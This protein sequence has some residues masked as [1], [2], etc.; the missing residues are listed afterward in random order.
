MARH[1]FL[2]LKNDSGKCSY[3]NGWRGSD[4]KNEN[5]EQETPKNYSRQR[6]RFDKSLRTLFSSMEQRRQRHTLSDIPQVNRIHIDFLKQFDESFALRF[7]RLYGLIVI[8]YSNLNKSVNFAVSDENRFNDSFVQEMHSFIDST[9]EEVTKYKDLTTIQDFKFLD[10]E[11]VSPEMSCRNQ[12]EDQLFIMRL[13]NPSLTK[14]MFEIQ[15]AL[16]AFL[17][18]HGGCEKIDEQIYQLSH[19]T[20]QDLETLLSNF[21]NILSLRTQSCRRLQI[22]PSDFGEMYYSTGLLIHTEPSL[23]VIGVID[24]GAIKETPCQEILTGEGVDVSNSVPADPF[25]SHSDHGTTVSCL[26]AFGINMYTNPTIY[27][28]EADAQIYTIKILDDEEGPLNVMGI[29]KSIIDAYNRGIRIFNLSV[30]TRYQK[31]YNS[32]ISQ[33]GYILDQLAYHYDILFFISTGNIEE[34][35]IKDLLASRESAPSDRKKYFSH[36]FHFFYP[37]DDDEFYSEMSNLREP[38]DSMNNM[39]VGALA[40]NFIDDLNCDLSQNKCYPAIYTLKG[41]FD[42]N[43]D[44]N[45]TPLNKNQRNKNLFKPDIVMP[46]GDLLERTSRMQVIG[47]NNGALDYI[48]NSGTSYAAPLAANLAAKIL[49]KYP[50][51]NMQTVKAIIINSCSMVDYHYLEGVILDQKQRYCNANHLNIDNLDSIQKRK[52]SSKFD[53]KQLNSRLTG[54]GKPNVDMCLCTQD[55][56]MVSFVIEEKIRDNS[57]KAMNINLPGYLFADGFNTRIKIKATLC[58]KF[59]PQLD[60]VIGYNPLHISFNLC[61]SIDK[62]NPSS[63]ADKYAHWHASEHNDDM[64]IKSKVQHWSDDFYPVSNKMF[65]NVQTYEMNITSDELRRIDGQICLI[66]RCASK[67]DGDEKE[68][69]FSIVISITENRPSKAET[70]ANLYDEMIAVNTIENI[71]E[72]TTDIEASIEN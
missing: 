50:R 64:R 8:S 69:P 46:G 38:A 67:K 34:S 28:I 66:I 57:Y 33:F 61:N 9:D 31:E 16:L 32:G 45:G 10:N 15:D 26:A 68:N 6:E 19:F 72:A 24:T 29:Q 22:G 4:P 40:D 70:Q 20:S 43:K 13:A 49:R 36:P 71:A 44:V 63:N 12:T 25:R 2:F 3:F 42:Y 5:E 53:I 30:T 21:D 11:E 54:H 58:Y 17:N 59:N 27:D 62:D 56:N 60:D 65:S 39:T 41:T 7:Q 52:L 14:K 55:D 1:D 48:W 37:D 23:P 51:I 47:T 35:D 18:N